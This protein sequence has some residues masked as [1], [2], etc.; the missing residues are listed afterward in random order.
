M[1]AF[2]ALG[3]AL[4]LAGTGFAQ[5]ISVSFAG[6]NGGG[7]SIFIGGLEP[8]D[9]TAGVVPVANWNSD[10][11]QLAEGFLDSLFDDSGSAT[12]AA[13]EWSGS[14]NTWGGSGA[15]TSDEQMVNGWLDDNGSGA[16][17][18]VTGIPYDNYDLYVYGSSDAGNGG[19]G[20]TTRVNGD[21]YFS[22]G[23]FEDLTDN[24]SY[25]DGIYVDGATNENNPSYFRIG[26]LSGAELSIFGARNQAGPE[27]PNG[28]TDYRGP[29]SGFQIVA[30]DG[31]CEVVLPPPANVAGAGNIGA[32]AVGGA[33][34]N[35]VFGDAVGPNLD[36]LGQTW[37]RVANP[38]SKA[39]IDSV[40]DNNEPTVPYFQSSNGSTWWSGSDVV[41]DLATYP[42][43]VIDGIPEFD[44]N[45]YSVKLEGEILI[46]ESGAVQFLDGVDD[47]TYLAIDLDRSG[48]AGDSETEVLIND[49]DWTNALSTGNGG[50]PIVT[51][52]FD[53]IAAGGEWL[54][55]EMNIAEGGGGDS[56]VLYWDA[57]D[58]DGVFPAAQ[59]D[60][61]DDLDAVF[62]MVP[63]TH[64]R[65]PTEPAPLVSADITGAIPSSSTGWAFEVNAADGTSDAFVLDNPDSDVFTTT[66]DLADA[67]FVINVEGDVS[68]GDSF[69]IVVA[70]EITGSATVLT[71]GWSF[72]ASTGLVTFGAGPLCDPN[73]QGDLDGNGMVEFADF[74]ILSGNFGNEVSDH[75]EGDI[76]C[77]GS[78]EFADFLV[79]SGNFGTTVGAE[80]VPEPSS[81][82]LM[83][84]AGAFAGLLRRKRAA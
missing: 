19:R 74:L 9:E 1:R 44:G 66:L 57:L 14:A 82:A 21:D 31:E 80:S 78:V 67:E 2:L 17:I 28:S 26:G 29:V 58:I 53:D 49:N 3:I 4:M 83:G 77:N 61:V 30:C 59:G 52:E 64:L 79:L 39:G 60:G 27:L 65:S 42:D 40:F 18:L 24:G 47:F 34:M 5:V 56:G 48:V 43:E 73:S 51:A 38:G 62:L 36:G 54:A 63:D 72:D 16:D 11:E 20:F 81:L 70:D 76:D 35:E 8:I 13:V 33:R 32:A 6:D 68:E 55:M 71:E 23:S 75:T 45:Q 46:E 84:L 69:Q 50:A 10:F 7:D 22:G 41:T 25:F 37:Y 15:T 12:T